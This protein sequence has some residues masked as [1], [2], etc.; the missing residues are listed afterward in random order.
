M[1]KINGE[2]VDYHFSAKELCSFMASST[3]N[4]S[5]S[6]RWCSLTFLQ[7]KICKCWTEEGCNDDLCF[8]TKILH[9]KPKGLAQCPLNAARH[10]TP[11][12]LRKGEKVS[13]G[14]QLLG[15][16]LETNMWA[17]GS[18]M[19][20]LD[21]LYVYPMHFTKRRPPGVVF[22]HGTPHKSCSSY[23]A[24]PEY[25]TRS[26]IQLRKEENFLRLDRRR[27]WPLPPAPT[28][29]AAMGA[30]LLY[31]RPHAGRRWGPGQGAARKVVGRARPRRE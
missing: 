31:L 28:R 6:A 15:G 22:L 9:R 1:I 27:R 29:E 19:Y 14:N 24:F 10:R 5:N 17:I 23:I 8:S 30:E 12:T 26:G 13:P 4:S 11:K 25:P 7:I 21:Y 2:A 18:E 3:A 20:E 16:N